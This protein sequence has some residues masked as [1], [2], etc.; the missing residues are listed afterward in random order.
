MNRITDIG[1]GKLIITMAK[2]TTKN[3]EF[4]SMIM[5]ELGCAFN[6]TTWDLT[7]YSQISN[8]KRCFDL[9]R[10]QLSVSYKLVETLSL[11][12]LY[13]GLMPLESQAYV[14]R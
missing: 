14:Q 4:A 1:R 7:Q 12:Y 11:Q 2:A 3:D 6:K 9:P 10:V 8:L 13:H 5:K